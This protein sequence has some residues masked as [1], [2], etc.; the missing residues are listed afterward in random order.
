MAQNYFQG[1]Q[2]KAPSAGSWASSLSLLSQGLGQLFPAKAAQA[3]TLGADNT[4]GGF[5][6]V[7]IPDSVGSTMD[8]SYSNPM[9]DPMANGG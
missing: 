8:A 9:N 1:A 2:M 4:L 7:G 3:P 5:S 6:G